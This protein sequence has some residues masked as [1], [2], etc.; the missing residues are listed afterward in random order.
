MTDR[1]R[2]TANFWNWLPAF[3]AVAETEHLPSATQIA[4][5]TAPALSRAVRQLESEIG[6]EL[7]GREGRGLQLNEDGRRLLVAVRDAMRLVDDALVSLSGTTFAGPLRWTCNWSLSGIAL[8][9]L[10]RLVDEHPQVVPPDAPAG[11]R[12][13]RFRAP[14]RRPRSGGDQSPC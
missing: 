7:F 4:H 5:V 1:F 6:H 13:P 12:R 3:R 2:R 10:S 11:A 8:R 9:A 14:V